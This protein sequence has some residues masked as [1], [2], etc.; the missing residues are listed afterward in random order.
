[1]HIK[2]GRLTGVPFEAARHHGGVISPEILIVHDTASRLEKGRG[3][4]YLKDNAAKVSV[5]FVV[6]RDGSVVQQVPVNRRAFHAGRSS[7]HGRPDCNAFSVGIEIV[8]PG[9]MTAVANA[10]LARAWWGETFDRDAWGIA[11]ADPVTH[12]P[13][14]WMAYTPEQIE[15][16]EGLATRLRAS[17][18]VT[19]IV[20]HWYVAPGRKTDTNPLFPLAAIRGRVFGRDEAAAAAAD[21][22]S[23]SATD[24]AFVRVTAPGDA[25][26]LRAWPSFNPNVVATVPD[27]VV[28]PVLRRGDFDDRAWLK[29]LH[30]GREGWIV[31]RYA[32]PVEV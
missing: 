32:S 16:V 15:A 11:E 7:Y 26:N 21:G 14:L 30:G 18:R 4:A 29:I 31:A 25:V 24:G 5:H 27:G 8:N 10:A 28:V 20:A 12:G 9:R 23:E 2:S 17:L 3:A 6:E 19:D 22:G 13:G 1:M